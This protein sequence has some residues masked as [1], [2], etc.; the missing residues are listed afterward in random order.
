MMIAGVLVFSISVPLVS[1][2]IS[3]A[4]NFDR[5]KLAASIAL[6]AWGSMIVGLFLSKISQ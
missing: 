6:V 4:E 2:L 5:G 3:K 1:F